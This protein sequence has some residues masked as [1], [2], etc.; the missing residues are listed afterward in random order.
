MS[1]SL[2]EKLGLT[3]AEKIGKKSTASKKNSA[4]K[5]QSEK[6]ETGAPKEKHE[7]KPADA[8]TV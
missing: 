4:K 1:K 8:V 7:K 6:S 2:A 3:T 5:E